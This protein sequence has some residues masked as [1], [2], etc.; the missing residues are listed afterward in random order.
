MGAAWATW[1]P[2][3]RPEVACSV[4][5][6]GSDSGPSIARSTAPILGHFADSDPYEP[7]ER[8]AAFER[9]CRDAG[10][11]L[12]LHRYPDTGH[13]FAEPSQDA[14]VAEAADLA[15]TRSVDFLRQHLARPGG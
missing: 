14:H 10:R 8:V 11:R 4:V 2:A 5:Y 7:E 6:Y 1:L 3:R 13:W 9:A 12:V 15:F